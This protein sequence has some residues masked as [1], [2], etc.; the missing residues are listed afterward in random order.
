M[1]V[2]THLVKINAHFAYLQKINAY[3]EKIMYTFARYYFYTSRLHPPCSKFTK[4]I[5]SNIPKNL[6]FF[7]KFLQIFFQ[8][9]SLIPLE[10]P[11]RFIQ[12][13]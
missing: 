13:F 12:K 5:F 6:I 4:N 9:F 7:S 11:Q 10:F 8:T 1:H 2:F 3:L